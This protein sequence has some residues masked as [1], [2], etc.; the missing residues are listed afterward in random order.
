MK[1]IF[2][3][4]ST[5]ENIQ[6][7]QLDRYIDERGQVMHMLRSDD[8]YFS[9]FGEIYFTTV[10]SGEVK[11]W[12]RHLKKTVNL[13]VVYG[14]MKI[15]L[16][17]DRTGVPDQ[18]RTETVIAG[19]ENYVLVVIPPGIWFSFKAIGSDKAIMA[20]CATEPYMP[21][22]GEKKPIDTPDIPYSWDPHH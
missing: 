20:D 16:F 6:V 22:E 2:P 19:P 15:V 10:F 11:G 3:K 17:D 21:G 1:K 9:K 14:L 13:A 18:A 8:P 5:N 12:N 7:I 4:T